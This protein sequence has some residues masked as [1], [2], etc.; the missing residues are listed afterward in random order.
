MK[1]R[2][3]NGHTCRSSEHTFVET[4]IRIVQPG[5]KLCLKVRIC[6]VESLDL[7][8]AG[9]W[10]VCGRLRRRYGTPAV[11][12]PSRGILLVLA[13]HPIGTKDV[14]TREGFAR[15]QDTGNGR[16]LRFSHARDARLLAGLIEQKLLLT[17]ERKTDLWTL[18][19]A[20]LFYEPKPFRV[21]EGVAAY[22]RY[23]ITA[24]PI[25]GI[26][27]GI[28]IDVETAFFTEHSVAWFFDD[29]IPE[30][31]RRLRRQRFDR[32]ST[33]QR[34][35]KGTLM[36]DRGGQRG[37]CYFNDFL[38]GV[39]CSSPATRRSFDGES[40]SSL[41]DY[42]QRRYPDLNVPKEASVAMVSFPGLDNVPV[43]AEL[44][45]LRVMNDALPHQMRGTV[46][47]KPELRARLISKFW[48]QL[49]PHPLGKG[50]ARVSPRFW[51]PPHD[52]VR[53]FQPPTLVFGQGQ[54]L[55]APQ[56]NS[57]KARAAHLQQRL[58]MLDRHGCFYVPPTLPR[59]INVCVPEAASEEAAR[60][61]AD[62]LTQRLS[63]WTRRPI[64][65]RL[66][67]YSH[68]DTELSKLRAEQPAMVVFVLD[69]RDPADYFFVAYELSQARIK[70][71]QLRT[72]SNT[73]EQLCLAEEGGLERKEQKRVRRRWSQ[74]ITLSA[75][76]VLEQLG[77][78][79]FA[80][81][82]PFDHEATLAIDVGADR[83]HFALSLLVSRPGQ[84]DKEEVRLTT[85]TYHKTDAKHETIN[86]A[87]LAEEIVRLV[88]DAGYYQ[89]K[90]LGSL[91]VL[92][93]GRECGSELEGIRS[94]QEQLVQNGLL[95][96]DGCVD[97]VDF[98]KKTLKGVRLWLRTAS[99]AV[100]SAIE[101]T[102]VQISDE[103]VV[104]ACTGAPTLPKGTASPVLIEARSVSSNIWAAASTVHG[105]AHL[106][107]SSPGVAQRL[108]LVMKQADAALQNKM[109]QEVRRFQ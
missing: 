108:P 70:R 19:S 5:T 76:D 52:R 92:R 78:V 83:R 79:P 51:Q 94:A 37:K 26:G 48:K 1:G 29:S 32:L 9:L 65:S 18:D 96:S 45:Y 31:Q 13:D 80:N 21:R 15:V 67:W 46:S 50:H 12:G 103:L 30:E 7:S 25:E 68:L 4:N 23:R 27:V 63:R 53:S 105:G 85:D 11:P 38:D 40:Y 100:G 22:R 90:P 44:L 55:P 3:I 77:C 24:L 10:K 109:A 2:T 41:C 81:A 102:A 69:G 66:R 34:G 75:L 95:R 87:L 106:N 28:A 8:L 101:G 17:L 60:R 42:Y 73:F 36:Y 91:L 98:H 82:E 89:Q 43:A 59:T 72:L 61:F 104:L 47:I 16:S 58:Q 88:S 64:S 84:N 74:F 35:M 6:R 97:V 56:A 62:A 93:D 14:S 54:R 33:R 86:A 49:G 107:W 39:V 20:R 57:E 71:I 99:G